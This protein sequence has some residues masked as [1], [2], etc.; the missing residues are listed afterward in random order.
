MVC[1]LFLARHALCLGNYVKASMSRHVCQ[2]KAALPHCQFSPVTYST[3]LAK[4]IHSSYSYVIVGAGSAGCVLANRLSENSSESVLLIEAGPKDMLLGCSHLSW[5]IHM[6]AALTYNLCDDKY[7]WYYHTLPQ[8]G[9]NNRLMYWPRGR[10]WGGS[11]SLNAMVYIRG[12]AEDYNRWHWEG[13]E[14]WNY[15]HCLP[16]FRKSQNHELGADRY[17]GGSGP[18]HVSRGKT[19]HPLHHAFIEAAQQAGYSFTDDMNGYQQEGFGWLDMTIHQGN[20]LPFHFKAINLND[21]S[22]LFKIKFK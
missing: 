21:L 4:H 5:K 9:M 1:P 2:G 14:G 11:S 20:F 15:E 7:N 10:V 12:H 6:P 16:Y 3:V 8:T 18:L 13:A 17:R 22:A 19:D